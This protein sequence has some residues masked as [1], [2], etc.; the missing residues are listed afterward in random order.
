MNHQPFEDWLLSKEAL[1]QE[2][3]AELHQHL[4]DCLACTNLATAWQA[5]EH[6]I[7]QAPQ[8]APAPRFN[9]RWQARLAEKRTQKQRRLAWWMSAAL[10]ILLALNWNR[11]AGLSFANL[12]VNALYSFTLLSARIESAETLARILFAEVNP[13]IPLGVISFTGCVLTLL[14][15]IWIASMLKIFIP[16]GVRNEARH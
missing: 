11:L 15:L 5:V 9:E 8:A 2:Q 7:K 1:T 4:Q 16:Q 12:L 3:E 6:E 13:L 14:C 10:G